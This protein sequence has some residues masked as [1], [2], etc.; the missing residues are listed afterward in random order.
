MDLLAVAIGAVGSAAVGIVLA[1]VN[2]AFKRRGEVELSER[3]RSIEA[4]ELVGA[5]RVEIA[6]V[7]RHLDSVNTRVTAIDEKIERYGRAI[8]VHG[9]RIEAQGAAILEQSRRLD[10]HVEENS[11]LIDNI[12]LVR[13]GNQ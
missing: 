11:R 10:E 3:R 6:T 12:R 9:S 5:V 8:D 4:A 1:A 7:I 2:H 13:E